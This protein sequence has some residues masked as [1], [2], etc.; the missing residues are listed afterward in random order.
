MRTPDGNIT[1]FNVKGAGTASGQGTVAGSNNL[2]G[3]TAGNYIDSSGV[4]HG[5]L[6]LP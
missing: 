2:E 6:R 3:V 4:Y 1:K 5:F